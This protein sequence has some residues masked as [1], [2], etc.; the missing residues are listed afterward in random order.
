MKKLRSQIRNTEIDGFSDTVLRLYKDDALAQKEEFLSGLMAELD[1]LSSQITSAILQDRAL[2]MLDAADCERDEAIK[3]LGAVLGAYA[4]F[5][6]AAKK[7][8]SLPLKAIYDKYAKAGIVT[9]NYASES[10]MI[11]SL[12]ED[13]A[14]K[15][16]AGNIAGLEGVA[17][18]IGAIRTAQDAFT[19]AN[20][21]YVKA[22]ASK[23]ASASSYNKPI[24]SLVNERLVPYLSTMQIMGNKNCAGFAKNIEVEISRMN[25]SIAK[26]SGKKASA[27]SAKEA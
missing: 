27:E 11:E 3:T 21:D 19:K 7:E 12:L 20:D 4:V 18:A 8:L 26:R 17:E 13:F 22:N 25:E 24:V 16:I 15:E 1:E 5:P 23:S 6:I 14:A 10:S 9:A 2:S